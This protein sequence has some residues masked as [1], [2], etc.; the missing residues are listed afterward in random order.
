MRENDRCVA[1]LHHHDGHFNLPLVTSVRKES[2]MQ[3]FQIFL[4]CN[5]ASTAAARKIRAEPDVGVHGAARNRTGGARGR[6]SRLPQADATRRANTRGQF[7]PRRAVERRDAPISPQEGSEMKVVHQAGRLATSLGM[8][9]AMAGTAAAQSI[10][11]ER[12][13]ATINVGQTFTINKTITLGASGATNVD[14]FFLA[15]NTGSMGGIVNNAK[16][17][18]GA[19]LE[20]FGD[21]FEFGVGRYLGDP[22]ESGVTAAT[23]YTRQL[24]MTTDKAS[25]QTAI[26]GWFASG[27]GDLPEAN[28]FALKQVSETTSWRLGAQRIVV[29]FGDATSHTRTVTEAETIAALQAA[30]VRVVAFNSLGSGS[31]IDGTF[32]GSLNQ[33]SKIVAGA[34]GSLTNNFNSLSGPTFVAA[35]NSAISSATSTI[36]LNFF[37]TYLGDGLSI[38]FRC[39][40]A[41]GCDDVA[42]GASRQFAVD[43]TGL[44]EGTYNFN[45]GARGVDALETDIIRVIGG[46][47]VPEPGTFALMGVGILALGGVARRRRTA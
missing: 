5:G 20:G 21:G 2:A 33:A 12:V 47:S 9:A 15:D 28:F 32:G 31:G 39:T 27:G 36:D 35:V 42:A 1:G 19:I 26:N 45:I 34:G 17:G 40:D 13:E 23:A 37:S 43:I 16:A 7:R 30:G 14:L 3:E 24:D 4:V 46:A 10:T 11:P 44:A 22:S 8:L 38:A 25:V 6:G 18:A 41:L 29:W